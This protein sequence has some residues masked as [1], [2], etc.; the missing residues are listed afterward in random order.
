MLTFLVSDQVLDS[1]EL[2]LTTLLLVWPKTAF[3]TLCVNH[4]NV[5]R[6]GEMQSLFPYSI[7]RG[8]KNTQN[9]LVSLKIAL[10]V[11]TQDFSSW[12]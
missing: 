10:V 11:P 8:L 12:K 9:F 2:A 4:R 1:N 3:Y 7:N 6:M 5:S